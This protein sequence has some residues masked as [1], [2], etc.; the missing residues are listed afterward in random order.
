MDR[1]TDWWESRRTEG[2]KDVGRART[3]IQCLGRTGNRWQ[4]F[5]KKKQ[6]QIPGAQETK[7]GY[8][9]QPEP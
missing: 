5:K 9:Q 7:R 4:L 2:L 1:L 3:P 8:E 6:D